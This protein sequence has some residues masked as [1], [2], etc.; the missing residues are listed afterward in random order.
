MSP[1]P[2]IALV[3]ATPVA[4]DP[5]LRAFA[6]LW[7]EAGTFSLLDDA[8][9]IDRAR[10]AAL[11]PAM[12][13]RIGALADYAILAEAN[14]ILFTCSA[15]GPAIEVAAARLPVPVL[16]PN[17]AMFAEAIAVG[18]DLGMVATF[19][20]SVD[21]MAEEFAEAARARGTPARLHTVMAEGALDALKAG[22]TERHNRLVASS[23][24]DLKGCGAIL[25]AHFSTARAASTVMKD[26]SVPVVT[27]PHAAVRALRQRVD[28][29]QSPVPHDGHL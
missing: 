4:V 19:S 8:L 2:R 6:T 17:E 1:R 26:S 23:A 12:T 27:A 29:T 13:G 5:V 15:F 9:S 11:T 21:L 3:H 18:G 7:P 25:L 24:R 28:G 16:K 14:A 22:D 20:P 10:S